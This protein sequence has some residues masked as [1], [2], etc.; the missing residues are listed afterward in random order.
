MSSEQFFTQNGWTTN[1]VTSEKCLAGA[2]ICLTTGTAEALSPERR[3]HT[4]YPLALEMS[5]TV[6]NGMR[7]GEK[8]ASQTLDLSSAAL[9]FI[10]ADPLALG[11]RVEVAINWPSLLDGCIPLQLVATGEVVRICGKEMVVTLQHRA[12]KTRRAQGKL[13]P[14]R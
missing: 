11:I 2:N 5:Y 14:I 3:R 6:L 7:R 13:V 8:G 4:R 10:A 1:H 9:R 12:F